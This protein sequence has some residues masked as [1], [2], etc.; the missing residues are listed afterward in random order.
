V[1]LLRQTRDLATDAARVPPAATPEPLID[2]AA[3]L[4]DIGA[5]AYEWSIGDDRIVW[6]ANAAGVLG[7]A[8]ETIAT[9]RDFASLLDPGETRSRHDAILNTPATDDGGGVPY[10]VQYTLLFGQG[11]A[12][13]RLIVEDTGRWYADGAGRPGRAHGMIRVIN[14]RVEREERRAFLSRFD[15]LTGF[16]NRTH[17]VAALGDALNGVRRS[18]NAIAFLIVA[19]DNFRA[20]N[21]AYDFDTADQVFA[22]V[23]RRIKAQLREGDVIGRYA[24]NK[25]GIVLMNCGEPEMLVAAERF[26]AAVRKDVITTETSSLAVTVSIGGVGLPRHARTVSETMARAQESLHEA[27]RR[28]YGH[29]VAYAPSPEREAR[30]RENAALS[31]DLVAALNE[32]RLKLWFQPVVGIGSRRAVFHE[33]LLRLERADGSFAMAED[34]IGLSE[35]LGL[36]RLIDDHVLALT[37]E[38]L[39]AVPQA[40]L[41]VNVSAETVGDAGWLSRVATAVSGRPDL[42]GRLIVEITETAVIRNLEEASR[43]VATLH[44]LGCP[45][46][47]DDFGAGFSSFRNLRSL[48]V[49]MVK[50]AGIFLGDLPRNRDD[51]AFVKALATLAQTFSIRVVAEWVEDEETAKL[52]ETFGVDMIQGNLTGGAGSADQL[53]VAAAP[54]E[55]PLRKAG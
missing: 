22:A 6:Q 1:A 33:C 25:L 18:R 2:T 23:G 38:T 40:R 35:R 32:K 7:V 20:I 17:L 47:I 48:D 4:A 37:L 55:T 13:R 10:E 41:S 19:V 15:D 49:D 44:D 36:I 16:F 14:E 54:P 42:A 50:I 3:M 43:F 30:Q 53:A 11:E 26:H 27:R 39:E 29:F 21:E 46:A 34:F 24:G 5:V 31:S 8:P 9:G 45:V 51:Q 12:Q 52:L 28:G